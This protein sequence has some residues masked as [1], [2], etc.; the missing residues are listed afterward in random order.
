MLRAYTTI[1]IQTML[2]EVKSDK[3]SK[4][5]DT[6]SE[7]WLELIQDHLMGWLIANADEG[8]DHF[9]VKDFDLKSFRVYAVENFD[10]Q[11]RN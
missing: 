4:Y 2:W 8:L 6:Y 9:L 10:L 5:F 11:S 1:D 7:C 3:T